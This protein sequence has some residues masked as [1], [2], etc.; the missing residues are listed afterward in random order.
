[1]DNSLISTIQRLR[2]SHYVE[3]TAE[4]KIWSLKTAPLCRHHS[5]TSTFP[6]EITSSKESEDNGH[7]FSMSQVHISNCPP[8]QNFILK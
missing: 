4:L 5:I 8:K 7:P 3:I 2:S 1:M 6:T